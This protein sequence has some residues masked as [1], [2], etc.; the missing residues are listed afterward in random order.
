MN[1]TK[2]LE[3]IADHGDADARVWLY[4]DP[5]GAI[6]LSNNAVTRELVRQE[7]YAGPGWDDLNVAEWLPKLEQEFGNRQAAE[8][9]ARAAI[10]DDR[11]DA[12][13]AD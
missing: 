13:L 4:R 10:G 5:E 9:F 6:Y 1:Q 8:L 3:L 2:E 12:A 7:Q 11:V